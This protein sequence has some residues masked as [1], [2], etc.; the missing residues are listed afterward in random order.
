MANDKQWY[1][2]V[3]PADEF[4]VYEEMTFSADEEAMAHGAWMSD[5]LELDIQVYRLVSTEQ[6]ATKFL[7]DPPTVDAPDFEA[8]ARDFVALQ[9]APRVLFDLAA[10]QAWALMAQLQLACR[11]PENQGYTRQVAEDIAKEIGIRLAT[12]PALKEVVQRGWDD[13]GDQA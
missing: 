3:D 8:F 9:D 12:T 1:L 5:Q 6:P 11:R 4:E 7:P 10:I 2:F 13:A